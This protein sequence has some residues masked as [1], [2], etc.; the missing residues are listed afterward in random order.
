MHSLPSRAESWFAAR[1]LLLLLL[2]P[3]AAADDLT[4]LT[5]FT[6]KLSSFT[7][8]FEQTV[9]DGDSNPLQTST[10]TIALKRPGRF[11]WDYLTPSP[12]TIVSDGD[13][14]WLYD[15][16]LEQVTVS[17]LSERAAG[18]PLALLMGVTPLTEEFEIKS[19]GASDGV[20]WFELTPKTADTDFESV[21]LGL[22]GDGLA[23]MEL[24]DS[25]GQATQ[26]RFHDFK[27]GV[28][29]DDARFHFVVPEGVDVIGQG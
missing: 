27:S 23:V 4:R 6:D 20:D 5:T 25:F 9:Y 10:G 13:K 12:Q 15:K 18:T 8:T 29:I 17:P 21:F 22:Q 19:L 28:P 14:V 26:I 3:A 24:R 2:A 16:E 1:L 7:A 11:F